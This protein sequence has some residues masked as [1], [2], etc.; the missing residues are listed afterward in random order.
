MKISRRLLYKPCLTEFPPKANLTSLEDGITHKSFC[1]LP[2]L[3]AAAATE[4]VSSGQGEIPSMCRFVRSGTTEH[5]RGWNCLRVW[6]LP[7][8][9]GFSVTLRNEVCLG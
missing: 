6:W 5:A 4:P 7:C 1:L 2:V 3:F 8:S 9:V